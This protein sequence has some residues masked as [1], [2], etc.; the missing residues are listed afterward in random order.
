[1]GFALAGDFWVLLAVAF[2]GTLNPSSG[3]VSLFLPLEH[4]ALAQAI[5][6]RRRTA[7]FARYSLAGTLAG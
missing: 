4:T 2:L 1:M 7:V 6:A 5:P 3:D